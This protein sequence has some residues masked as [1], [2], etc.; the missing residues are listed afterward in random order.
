[1]PGMYFEL[2]GE[3]RDIEVIAVGGSIDD[4]MRLR[5]QFG[6]GRW[7]KLKGVATV[8]TARGTTRL[9]E[10]HWYEAHGIGRKKMK[11]KRFLD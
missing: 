11:I 3:I 7:R 1:M 5:H 4:I 2:L 9:A 10:L 6:P 8:R